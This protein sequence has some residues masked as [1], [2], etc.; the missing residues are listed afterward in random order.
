[1]TANRFSHK[2]RRVNKPCGQ[3][4]GGVAKVLPTLIVALVACVMVGCSKPESANW[5]MN[6]F[7]DPTQV[8]QFREERRNE[9]RSVISILE[10]PM[11]IQNAEEP[12]PDDLEVKF[13]E[14]RVAPGDVIVITIFELL[15]SGQSTQS[16]FRVN[17]S[18]YE[19]L[20]SIGRIRI[21]GFTTRELELQIKQLLREAD[22]LEDA[23]VQVAIIESRGQQFTILGSVA[24]PGTYSIP[25]PNYRL[26]QALAEAGGV[27]P[28]IER[29]Y[30]FRRGASMDQIPSDAPISETQVAALPQKRAFNMS[31]VSH[32]TTS[33]TASAPSGRPTSRSDSS[34]R[35]LTSNPAS[36]PAPGPAARNVVEP[37]AIPD[38]NLSTS[39]GAA[40]SPATKSPSGIDEMEILEGRPTAKPQ[41]ITWDPKKGGWIIEGKN[42]PEPVTTAPTLP[43]DRP[44]EPAFEQ[45]EGPPIRILEIPVKELLDGDPRYNVVIRP[46]DLVNVPPGAVGEYYM[47]GNVARPGA[48]G[49]SGR[50]PTIKEAI[51]AAGGFGPL[52]WP[53]RVDLVRRISQD[54]EQMIQVDLDAIYA[55]N[56]PDLYLKPND[57]INVGT[58]P[59]AIFLAVLRNAFRFTYGFGFIYDRN[60]ADSDS[61]QAKEQIKSRRFQEAQSRGLPSG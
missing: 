60:F 24:R 5:F 40:P 33:S 27:S 37:A 21:A 28:L 49:L 4:N 61:F 36:R 30:V 54:E 43:N 29:V 50:R 11:G 31:D 34:S 16:Q 3:F 58:T 8:G 9:I 18:G 55:G 13:E 17:N 45:T 52:A 6:G 42:A 53:S 47:Q 15:E 57:L 48:Y 7:L 22:V 35:G 1:V 59:V 56:A 51:A 10:E 26:L 44:A 25:I 20:P 32:T 14:N 46:F 12:T 23:E 19:T 2:D 38:R 41:A 39:R